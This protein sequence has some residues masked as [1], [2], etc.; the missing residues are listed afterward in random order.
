MRLLGLLLL[1]AALGAVLAGCG[2][3]D[4][5]GDEAAAS[6]RAFGAEL[7]SAMS[8]VSR[9][10]APVVACGDDVDCLAGAGGPLAEAADERISA[11]EGRVAG[12]GDE[13]VRGASEKAMRFLRTMKAL[14]LSAA[15]GDAEAVADVQEQGTRLS[16]ETLEAI[17]G[18]IPGADD[19]PELNAASSLQEVF[20]GIAAAGQRL[21]A[22]QDFACISDEGLA[23]QQTAEDGAATLDDLRGS[24]QLNAC[25]DHLLD[26]STQ[27]LGAYADAGAA[28]Q[29]ADE[30]AAEQAIARGR[31]LEA[32]VLSQGPC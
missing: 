17:R 1:V 32:E 4:G 7:S 10:F 14:G 3:G 21:A 20:N 15:D 26:L 27:A 16:T 19:N 9:R 31:Q 28:L 22:C 30:S 5:G 12:V 2:G 25:V 11:L 23:L 6:D 18:C 29:E 13:C 24:G 8:E